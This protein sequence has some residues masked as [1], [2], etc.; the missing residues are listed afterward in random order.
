VSRCATEFKTNGKLFQTILVHTNSVVRRQQPQSIQRQRSVSRTAP[1]RCVDYHCVG[2]LEQVQQPPPPQQEHYQRQQYR[3]MG[4]Y[5]GGARA[6]EYYISTAFKKLDVNQPKIVIH[7]ERVQLVGINLLPRPAQTIIDRATLRFR[8]ITH[9]DTVSLDVLKHQIAYVEEQE[10]RNYPNSPYP[11]AVFA[12][13]LSKADSLKQ[14]QMKQFSDAIFGAASIVRGTAPILVCGVPNSGKSSLVLALTRQRTL[15]VKNK[16]EYHLPKVSI[17]AGRTMGTKKHIMEYDNKQ[18]V[19]FMDS[20]GLRPRLQGLNP[21]TIRLLLASKSVEPFKGYA[22]YTGDQILIRLLLQAAN[23]YTN[24]DYE[25]GK[26]LHDRKKNANAADTA[27]SSP[28]L[29]DY[30]TA[31]GLSRSTE[32]P[33]EFVNAYYKTSQEQVSNDPLYLVR[34]FQCGDFGSWVFTP[35]RR[36]VLSDRNITNLRPFY[37][38]FNPIIY[39]NQAGQEYMAKAIDFGTMKRGLQKIGHMEKQMN[40]DAELRM[41]P[42]GLELQKDMKKELSQREIEHLENVWT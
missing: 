22:D 37:Q 1:N 6:E 9:C 29:P 32:D 15:K 33:N 5:S 7:C 31:F 20:P 42:K 40:A 4:R 17:Q 16:R 38:N 10:R 3:H 30:A 24:V 19:T 23:N 21:D 14:K 12:M 35:Y 34:K 11:T 27:Y 26:I 36:D 41:R 25:V 39:M 8:V 18:S 2:L 28:T 13:N